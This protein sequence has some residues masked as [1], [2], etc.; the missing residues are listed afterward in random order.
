MSSQSSEQEE[1]PTEVVFEAEV[2]VSSEEVPMEEWSS[3]ILE[4][5]EDNKKKIMAEAGLYHAGSG[6]ICGKYIAM[7]D[8]SVFRH[9]YYNYPAVLDPGI[10][11]ALLVPEKPIIYPDDGQEL[12]LAVC[13]EMNQ[14]PV[15]SFVKGLVE[16]IIDLRYYCVSPQGVR[17]MS[18]ALSNNCIVKVLNLTDNFLT[19][20]ACYHLSEM[21]ASNTYLEELN[22]AGCRVGPVGAKRIFDGL[23]KN[24]TLK[25]LNLNRNQLTDEGMEHLA[26]VVVKGVHVQQ[27]YL[28][29]NCIGGKGAGVLAEALEFHNRFTHVDLSWNNLFTPL[30]TFNLLSRFS[31]N[32]VL[33]ELNLSWNSLSGARLGT[34]VKNALCAP[35][36]K[37]LNLSNNRLN[38]EAITNIIGGLVKAK[39]LITLDL[40]FNPM[41]PDDALQI[42]M[43]VKAPSVKVHNVLMENVFVTG[44]FLM[45]LRTIKEMKSK[46]NLVVTYG[47]IIG[48]FKP[49]G[50]DPRELILDRADFLAKKPKKRPVDIAL[51]AMQLLK[52]NNEIMP[53]KDFATAVQG[54]CAALDNDL[55][56][57]MA[58]IFA[59]PRSAKAKTIDVKLLVDYMKRKWPDRKLP[60]TPPPEP[61]PLPL[62]EPAPKD[63]KGKGKGK[64]KKK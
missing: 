1:I 48:E 9:L 37:R 55:L 11:D 29:Y 40:S 3:Y 59:G 58:N 54:A 16:E 17:A 53:S 63:A 21:L 36:L 57:E 24:K 49:K 38:G 33:Q 46:K 6:E 60:P 45:F 18:L 35:N 2:E 31:E 34:A 30:G 50:P 47:G 22:L 10:T 14:C 52:D 13:K 26:A 23:T 42:L 28:S 12:Y 19:P 43:K 5:P 15:R 41:T 61:E 4:L 56:E 27:I 51:V 32:K 44:E 25:V 39:K 62:P 7:S 20:D 64:G 8:S